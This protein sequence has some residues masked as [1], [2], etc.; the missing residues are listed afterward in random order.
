MQTA[1][2]KSAT[3]DP[4]TKRFIPGW[5]A[6]LALE[7]LPV[8]AD[9]QAANHAPEDMLE[10][11]PKPLLDRLVA[12]RMRLLEQMH[13]QYQTAPGRHMIPALSAETY[14][15]RFLPLLMTEHNAVVSVLKSHT[16]Y[17]ETINP[18]PWRKDVQ[19][20]NKGLYELKAALIREGSPPVQLGD[21][22]WLKQIR[23][24]VCQS[25]GFTLLATIHA[26]NRAASTI[27]LRCDALT[28]KQESMSFI[29]QWGIQVSSPESA[30]SRS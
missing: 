3:L 18:I 2:P 27:I 16:L 15:A 6:N 1:Q 7:D 25:Q 10:V 21:T 12:A 9:Q 30:D 29:V 14:I 5:L 19:T 23:W 17:G 8:I 24:D 26:I 22:V 20:G 13:N 4:Y 11:W 28:D